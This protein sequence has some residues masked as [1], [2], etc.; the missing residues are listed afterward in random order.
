M[1]CVARQ[2]CRRRRERAHL[3]G[4]EGNERLELGNVARVER[5]QEVLDPLVLGGHQRLEDRVHQLRPV[6][7][8]QRRGQRTSSPKL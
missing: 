5:V 7:V 6:S 3:A 8:A 1:G 2:G 4:K